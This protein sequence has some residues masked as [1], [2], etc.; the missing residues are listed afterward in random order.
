MKNL[1]VW[2]AMSRKDLRAEKRA[3]IADSI[4][5]DPKL[6]TR[7]WAVYDQYESEFKALWDQRLANTKKYAARYEN[8]TD[9]IADEMART[10]LK[11]DRTCD[12]LKLKYYAR[13][14]AAVVRGWPP[15]SS[16]SKVH[17][18]GLS[19]CRFWRYYRLSRERGPIL[20]AYRCEG[21]TSRHFVFYDWQD[22][23]PLRAPASAS[24]PADL[25]VCAVRRALLRGKGPV[26]G[27]ERCGFQPLQ[28]L[29]VAASAS[30]DEDR[31]GRGR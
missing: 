14:K 8:M 23:P 11:N 9:A 20:H 3:I 19:N 15:D 1:G 21:T 16:T 29:R 5:L 24:S 25:A 6:E 4:G 22:D 26:V 13:F 2:A 30:P 28:N 7:F 31:C 18:T 12:S 17:W 10:L 27:W